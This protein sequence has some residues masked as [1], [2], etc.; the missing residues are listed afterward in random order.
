MDLMDTSKS[1]RGLKIRFYVSPRV[2]LQTRKKFD[3]VGFDV[4]VEVEDDL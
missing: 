3:M 2:P 4:E 1:F